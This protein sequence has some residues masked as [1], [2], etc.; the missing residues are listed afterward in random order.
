[1]RRTHLRSTAAALALLTGS[2]GDAS[3]CPSCKDAVAAQPD[4]GSTAGRGYN[5]SVLLMLAVP[6]TLAGAGGF[7]VVRASRLGLLPEL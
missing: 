1:M 2:A 6:L 5:W 7:A 3:A 4:D